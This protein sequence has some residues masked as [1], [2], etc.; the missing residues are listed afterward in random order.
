M[1]PVQIVIFIIQYKETIVFTAR[2][3]AE[4]GYAAVSCLTVRLSVTLGI[5]FTQVGILRK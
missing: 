1:T 5:L 4:C 3:Y 2:C